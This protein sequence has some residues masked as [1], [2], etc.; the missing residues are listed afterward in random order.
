M[1]SFAS[2]FTAKAGPQ[3]SQTLEV[4]EEVLRKEDFP[5]VEED[6]VREHLGKLNIPKSMG[7][8]GMHPR[9]LRELADVIA[10]PLSVVSERAWKTG[11]VPEDWRKASVTPVFKKGRKEDPGNC[12]PV[13]LTKLQSKHS[14]VQE[15]PHSGLSFCGVYASEPQSCKSC[16]SVTRELRSTG[17]AGPMS[18]PLQ[19]SRRAGQQPGVPA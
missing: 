19:T 9:A 8:D 14:K 6:W 4:G 16:R 13:S 17:A 12:R 11:E 3:E 5:S 10:R 2:V 1:Q 18:R 15:P 7:P